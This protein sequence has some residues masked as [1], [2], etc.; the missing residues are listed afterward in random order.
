MPFSMFFLREAGV[1]KN[2]TGTHE[3]PKGRQANPCHCFQISL[4]CKIIFHFS[5]FTSHFLSVTPSG[6]SLQVMVCRG[7]AALHPCLNSFVPSGLD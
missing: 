4:E 7:F 2:V 6:F 3:V 5:L 1:S